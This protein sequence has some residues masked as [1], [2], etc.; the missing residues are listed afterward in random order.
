MNCDRMNKRPTQ[1]AFPQFLEFKST[2][3]AI[4]RSNQKQ[5]LKITTR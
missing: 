1:M 3:S 5:A 2:E 4:F